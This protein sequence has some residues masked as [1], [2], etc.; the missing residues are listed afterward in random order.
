M[1][2]RLDRSAA[3]EAGRSLIAIETRPEKRSCPQCHETLIEPHFWGRFRMTRLWRAF[4]WCGQCRWAQ[5]T[6]RQRLALTRPPEPALL[7]A[8]S[9][10]QRG[11]LESERL[12]GQRMLLAR[13]VGYLRDGQLRCPTCHSTV[14][15]EVTL[16]R[17]QHHH[18]ACYILEWVCWGGG[19]LVGERW[20]SGSPV[21]GRFPISMTAP[22]EPR[23]VAP[24]PQGDP[25]GHATALTA[26]SQRLIRRRHSMRIVRMNDEMHVG[27]DERCHLLRY[28]DPEDHNSPI[29]LTRLHSPDSHN[30]HA[31]RD[32]V[33]V[34]EPLIWNGMRLDPAQYHLTVD[35][36]SL[37]RVVTRIEWLLLRAMFRDVGRIVP[38]AIIIKRTWGDEYTQDDSH[39]LRVHIARLRKKLDPTSNDRFITTHQGV[40]YGLGMAPSEIAAIP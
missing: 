9:F 29:Y 26:L 1:H 36:I 27:C 28:V 5:R 31:Q 24:A 34:S 3:T 20:R 38:Q 2:E 15:C 40:G 10:Q 13:G 11:A 35:G 33:P 17:N 21:A 16:V 37:A 6:R 14:Y 23:V 18:P 39:L 4:R 30:N 7:P 32:E 25:I 22:D 12:R 8:L 19:H